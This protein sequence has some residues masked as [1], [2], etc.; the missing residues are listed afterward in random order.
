MARSRED[1]AHVCLMVGQMGRLQTLFN[2]PVIAGDSIGGKVEGI[3]R[4][5]PLRRPTTLDCKVDFFV[6]F[7]PHRYTY[8]DDWLDFIRQGPEENIT[9][10]TRNLTHSGSPPVDSLGFNLLDGV[11]P[12]W[13]VDPY[14]HVWDRFFTPPRI[15]RPQDPSNPAAAADSLFGIYNKDDDVRTYG[16]MC[17][18]LKDIFSTG[19]STARYTASSLDELRLG[20]STIASS[21]VDLVDMEKARQMYESEILREWFAPRYQDLMP[22]LFGTKVAP[23]ITQQPRLC[24]HN[25]SWMSGRDVAGTDDATLGTLGGVSSVGVNW[26][27]PRKHFSEH[28]VLLGLCLARYPRLFTHATH[29]LVKKPQPT[30]LEISGDPKLWSAE[31]PVKMMRKDLSDTASSDGNDIGYHPYGQW[32]RYHPHRIHSTID[33]VQ[34]FPV[35]SLPPQSDGESRGLDAEFTQDVAKD[36]FESTQLAHWQ[37][38]GLCKIKASRVLPPGVSSIY[39]G[40]R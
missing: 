19:M 22:K 9:L 27:F 3:M 5:S 28:G 30:Y 7:V 13:V 1:L 8:G 11:V 26:T 38:N 25:S 37:I 33:A 14:L 16:Q 29:Y 15:Q 12:S 39:S 34:G 18:P 2:V 21:K 40:T 17:W 31:P 6:F 36:S 24:F 4:L 10:A 32:Y 23:E 20:A 35:T